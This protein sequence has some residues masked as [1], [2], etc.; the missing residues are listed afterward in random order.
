MYMMKVMAIILNYNSFEDSIHCAKLLKKQEN[1][2]LLITIVDNASNDS[3][4][5]DL[6]MF[7]KEN[8]VI[9]VE[10][11]VNKGFS[12]G[13]NMGLKKATEYK[14][15]YAMII[16]PDVEIR[17]ADYVLRSV[18]VM[19]Q[20]SDIAVLGT[21]I[22][23]M[24]GQHQNPMREARFLEEVLWPIVIMRN[25]IKKSLPFIKDY[26]KSGYC[27]KVTGCC[28]FVDM[29][30]ME[31]IEYIDDNV[32]LYCE[33]PILAATVKREGKKEY[34]LH[35]LTAYHMHQNSEKGNVVVRL[36]RFFESRKYY[37][38]KYSNYGKIKLAIV[39]ASLNLQKKVTISK[40]RQME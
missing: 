37:L 35:S 30:F 40:N 15:Q 27:E 34:Y 1:V 24:E 5:E 14:C 2:E 38:E 21:N 23:N 36:E 16:N 17:D 18:K 8:D 7:C 22:I 9:L 19:E 12:A 6:R 11:G 13:N 20:D 33:E 26:S 28:F 3:G 25:K 29:S 31:K 39:K 4:I 32:F 10:S